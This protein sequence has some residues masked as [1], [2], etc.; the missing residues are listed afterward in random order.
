MFIFHKNDIYRTLCTKEIISISDV[1]TED[2]YKLGTGF[3]CFYE[4]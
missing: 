4:E 2:Y 1:F 3:M